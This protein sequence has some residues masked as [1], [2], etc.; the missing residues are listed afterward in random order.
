MSTEI[1]V[2]KI[3]YLD[4]VFIDAFVRTLRKDLV[5][6]AEKKSFSSIWKRTCTDTHAVLTATIPVE[7]LQGTRKVATAQMPSQIGDEDRQAAESLGIE[8]AGR[9]N[10]ILERAFAES[11]RVI[12]TDLKKDADGKSTPV[13]TVRTLSGADIP[14]T[15]VL[16]YWF[17][18]GAAAMN[19]TPARI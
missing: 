8:A 3:I 18:F 6:R 14:E 15:T 2:Y 16:S 7:D 13:L 1:S 12:M 10:E 9:V 5:D 11:T 4:R 17:M 19:D